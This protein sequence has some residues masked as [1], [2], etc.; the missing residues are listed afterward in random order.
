MYVYL[1]I[2]LK[3][4]IIKNLFYISTNFLYLSTFDNIQV[5]FTLLLFI[6]A[7]YKVNLFLNSF[8]VL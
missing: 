8:F 4:L 5:Y 7:N 6:F 3:E 2:M 1:Y